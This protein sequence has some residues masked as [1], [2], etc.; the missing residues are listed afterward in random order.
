MSGNGCYYVISSPGVT[1]T[2]TVMAVSLRNCGMRMLHSHTVRSHLFDDSVHI[3]GSVYGY[4]WECSLSCAMKRRKG[5]ASE[6]LFEQRSF[7]RKRLEC[8]DPPIQ[9]I[10]PRTVRMY[11]R[12]VVCSA[13]LLYRLGDTE[14]PGSVTIYRTNFNLMLHQ[15][16]K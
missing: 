14:L 16:K 1:V 10:P 8:T 15:L 12:P 3:R 5:N 9:Y 4:A 6:K 11:V 7:S 2:I 13:G